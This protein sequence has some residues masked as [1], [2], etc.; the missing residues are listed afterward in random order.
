MKTQTMT[1]ALS[2]SDLVRSR[3]S[4]SG[5]HGSASAV[6]KQPT[7]NTTNVVDATTWDIAA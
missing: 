3:W 6:K 4:G 1:I 5:S 7:T 2:R